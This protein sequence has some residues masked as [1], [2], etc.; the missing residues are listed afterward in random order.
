M[1]HRNHGCK[2]TVSRLTLVPGSTKIVCVN[3]CISFDFLKAQ[4]ASG[5]HGT[6]LFSGRVWNRWQLALKCGDVSMHGC[7]VDS[8][9]NASRR[10]ILFAFDC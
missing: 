10:G 2:C 1:Q 4:D 8:S 9:S 3:F 7:L 6:L 5:W